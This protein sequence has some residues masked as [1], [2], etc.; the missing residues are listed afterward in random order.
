MDYQQA[1]QDIIDRL[2]P[3]KTAGIDIQPLPENQAAFKQPFEKAKITV[4][5]KGSKWKY[6]ASTSEMSQDEEV[7]FEFSI[8]S[9]TLRGNIGIYFVKALTIKALV[10]F[11]PTDCDKMYCKESGMTQASV[12]LDDG[13]WTYTLIMCCRNVSVEDFEEDLSVILRKIT[14]KN[15][16][17]SFDVPAT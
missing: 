2:I 15:N 13:V 4:A 14:N 6:P 12:A 10:G 17:S 9:R 1:E 16:G 8:Q 7:M 11:A 5:Y 3:F